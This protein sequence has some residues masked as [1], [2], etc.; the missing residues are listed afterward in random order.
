MP[1]LECLLE[2]FKL[3]NHSVGRVHWP[4]KVLSSLQEATFPCFQY[5]II[6]DSLESQLI[7]GF[8]TH[9][10][11]PQLHQLVYELKTSSEFLTV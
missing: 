1:Q 4:G 9:L 2:Q 3:A 5:L 7:K 11:Q 8:S 10:T 6:L